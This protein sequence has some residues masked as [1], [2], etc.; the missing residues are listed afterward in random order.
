[1]PA[2]RQLFSRAA[3]T[4]GTLLVLSEN[5]V[6]DSAGSFSVRLL[7]I[8]EEEALVFHAVNDAAEVLRAV[9]KG[10]ISSAVHTFVFSRQQPHQAQKMASSKR[11]G[12]GSSQPPIHF[13]K[14]ERESFL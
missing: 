8:A 3:A 2:A 6:L 5:K 14:V 1:L 11:L 9:C 13:F 10:P 4:P 12:R 7:S